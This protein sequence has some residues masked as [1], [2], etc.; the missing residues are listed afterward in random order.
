MAVIGEDIAR[1]KTT[2]RRLAN[3]TTTSQFLPSNFSILSLVREINTLFGINWISFRTNEKYSKLLKS[4]NNSCDISSRSFWPISKCNR[5]DNPNE[6]RSKLKVWFTPSEMHGRICLFYS[7]QFA[8]RI[9]LLNAHRT[10]IPT[11]LLTHSNAHCIMTRVIY[12][13]SVVGVLAGA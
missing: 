1:N 10:Q 12:T 3:V 5:S 2:M 11:S 8:G 13:F 9:I 6:K 4:V 7:K